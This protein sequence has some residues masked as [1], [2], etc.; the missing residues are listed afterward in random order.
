[1]K[2]NPT[3]R[4]RVYEI[5]KD[6][7]DRFADLD[8]GT[9]LERLEL[10]EVHGFTLVEDREE[11]LVPVAITTFFMHPDCL[12]VEWFYVSEDHRGLGYG[13]RLLYECFLAAN[14]EKKSRVEILL[15]EEMLY[16]SD[17]LYDIGFSPTGAKYEWR[18]DESIVPEDM[19]KSG[20]GVKDNPQ[21]I[22][23]EKTWLCT[24]PSAKSYSETEAM[25]IYAL[26]KIMD[27]MKVGE[28]ICFTGINEIAN[29][30]LGR[31]LKKK[32]GK[33]LFVYSA[34]A[35]IIGG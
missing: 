9:H 30:A 7:A 12:S 15:T 25:I 5:P 14:Q 24:I 21:P 3:F 8:D 28:D 13:E 2:N 29:R 35:H 31:I 34:P 18:F 20:D 32:V 27:Q 17:Y 26:D 1:M 4:I 10:P 16:M 19:L 11:G 6:L 22:K 23:L 33:T